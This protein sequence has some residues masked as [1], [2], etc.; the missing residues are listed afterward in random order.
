MDL[1]RMRP[2]W[3]EI[4]L[5]AVQANIAALKQIIRAPRLMAVVKAN[6][7]G[8]GAV[9]VATA[10]IESGADWLGV[11]TVEEGVTLRRHGIT[12]PILVLG[13]VSPG[14]ADAVLTE[15]LRVALFDGELGLALHRAGRRLGRKAR[16]H[17]KVDTGMGRIGLQPAEVAAVGR[18]LAGLSHVEVEGVFTHLATADEPENPY[19]RAQ[20]DRFEAALAELEAVGVRPAIRHVANSAG[21]MLHPEAHYDMV[22]SGI[23]V[24]GLPPAPGVDWPVKLTPALT[25]KTR[26][27]LVKWLEAGRS[28]SY[29]CTYTTAA[30]EQIATLPVGYADGF[31]RKLSNRAE[32]LIR[33]RRCPVVG[34]VTMDQTMVRVPDDV[35]VQVG[36]EVVLIGRQGDEEVT[37]TE[38]AGLA[39]TINYEIVCGISRRVPRFYPPENV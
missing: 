27:G 15:G 24:V 19:T 37:A 32:V 34:V 33:G 30:R 8:H 10:A 26:V 21:L 5:R 13:Y 3:A 31:S 12:A 6:A 36:D 29:N 7:Y 23:A 11:A 17:L 38:L 39:E 35:P 16:V 1:D 2:T 25:W 4:N 18:T 28:V 9:P 22:R 20:L 14:Q